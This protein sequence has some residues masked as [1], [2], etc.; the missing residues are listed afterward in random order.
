M[1]G[2]LKGKTALVTGARRGIG[3]AVTKCFASAGADVFACARKQDDSFEASLALLANE[4]GVILNPLYFDLDMS[5][6]V[7]EASRSLGALKKPIDILVNNAGISINALLQMSTMESLEKQLS[8]NFVGPM[9]LTQYVSKIM[10]KYGGGYIINIAS[11]AGLDGPM[12]RVGYGGS[13][14]ALICATKILAKELAGKNIRVNA[15]APGIINTE[16]LAGNM[17]D[18]IINEAIQATCLQRIGKPE[19]IANVALFLASDLSSYVTGQ[20]IRADGGKA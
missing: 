10:G 15:I 18:E 9:L 1:T 20:V 12:G 4:Y 16:M 7:R 2:L 13:K 8:S 5:E 19:E 3:M 6:Q 17:T 11:I 14:A